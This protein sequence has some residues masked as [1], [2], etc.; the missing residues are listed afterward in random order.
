MKK[1]T[2]NGIKILEDLKR[3]VNNS[4]QN[5]SLELN[6]DGNVAKPD[7]H[8]FTST[9]PFISCKSGQMLNGELCCKY[10]TSKFLHSP[11]F[12]FTNFINNV[13]TSWKPKYHCFCD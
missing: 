13:K 11:H 9:S 8:S 7:P 6:L 2:E 5:G 10:L 12:V 1:V 3:E 4:I